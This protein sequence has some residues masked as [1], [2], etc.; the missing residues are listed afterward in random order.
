M[1]HIWELGG[2]TLFTNLLETPLSPA[3]LSG[4]RVVALVDLSEPSRLWATLEAVVAAV[5]GHVQNALK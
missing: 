3:K 2:G 4:L 5:Q 1:C